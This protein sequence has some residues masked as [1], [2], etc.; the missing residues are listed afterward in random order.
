MCG[1][2]ASR[3]LRQNNIRYIIAKAASDVS[4]TTDLEDGGCLRDQ[5]RPGDVIIYNWRDG[6]RT[7]SH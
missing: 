2:G 3:G 5:R 7:T 6:R 4:F 1:G